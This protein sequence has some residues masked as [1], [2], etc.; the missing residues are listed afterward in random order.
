MHQSI[1][2]FVHKTMTRSRAAFCCARKQNLSYINSTSC[3]H[4]FLGDTLD[5]TY[6]DGARS[7]SEH[8]NCL[9]PIVKYW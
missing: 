3:C 6:T 2:L 8:R 7:Q 4:V 5:P 1:N 9:S